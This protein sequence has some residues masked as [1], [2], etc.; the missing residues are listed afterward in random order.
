MLRLALL[1]ALLLTAC[2]TPQVT[3]PVV[4]PIPPA[5][6][7]QP[8][9]NLVGCK[10]AVAR[11]RSVIDSDLE[12]GDANKTVHARMS[13]E[14]NGIEQTCNTGNEGAALSQLAGLKVK[15]GYPNQ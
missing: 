14:L 4:T 15:N 9:Q 3:A 2:T 11:F 12:S 1:T 13:S 7:T 6:K 5:Q 8:A 10:K